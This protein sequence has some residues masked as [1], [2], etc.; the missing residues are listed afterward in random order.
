MEHF[1][2]KIKI[3]TP[4]RLHCT[5]INLSGLHSR[6]DSGI[7]FSINKPNWVIEIEFSDKLDFKGIELEKELYD[8]AII[9]ANDF[10]EKYKLGKFIITIKEIIPLHTG[11]GAKTSFVLSLGKLISTLYDI[12]FDA[13]RFANQYFRG[14]TSGIGIHTFSSG[15]F[16]CDIGHKFPQ[17]KNSF[18]P[19][20]KSQAPTAKKL[21]SLNI[22][23]Y[24]VL[25]FRLTN[26][27]ISGNDE[28]ALF[29][30]YC[31][32]THEST[33]DVLASVFFQ[34]AA[35]IISN[36]DEALQAGLNKIQNSG[37]KKIEWE[38]Q[39]QIIKDFRALWYKINPKQALCLSS[40][41]PTLYVLGNNFDVANSIIEKFN[42][43]IYHRTECEF[44]NVGF[45]IY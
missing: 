21:F 15:G 31:P 36:D 2:G 41:G 3:I 37:F 20:S 38:I 16:V 30:T 42:T 1:K 45:K 23:N 14:S 35:G 6:V 44:N 43:K 29:Q 39:P 4:A 10:I 13:E 8:L 18:L 22:N 26:K 33:T 12:D 5:L 40:V 17:E 32:L 34:V 25:H 28:K 27:G 7:G 19:S 11:L 24:K 9:I